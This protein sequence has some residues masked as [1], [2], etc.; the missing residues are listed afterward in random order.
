MIHSDSLCRKIMLK[1]GWNYPLKFLPSV[2]MMCGVY[3]V[4]NIGSLP[5]LTLSAVFLSGLVAEVLFT[6]VAEV[7][8][9]RSI[10]ILACLVCT[11][12][13]AWK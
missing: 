1:T 2:G 12:I 7:F 4:S 10:Q 6:V 11:V 3:L 9:G 8:F 5:R 13:A